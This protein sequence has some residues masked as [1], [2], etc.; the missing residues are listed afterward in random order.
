VDSKVPFV[1][2]IAIDGGSSLL[3][4]RMVVRGIGATVRIGGAYH[5]RTVEHITPRG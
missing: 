4:R 5:E 1:D 2:P 3:H